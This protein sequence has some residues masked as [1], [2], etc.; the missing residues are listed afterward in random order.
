VDR[1]SDIKERKVILQKAFKLGAALV[2][3]V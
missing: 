1:K 3:R 2:N